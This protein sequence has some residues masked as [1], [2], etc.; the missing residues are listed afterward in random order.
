VSVNNGLGNI[1]EEMS[2]VGFEIQSWRLPGGW[3]HENQRTL[4]I[5]GLG[6]RF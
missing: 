2:V 6:P 4:R 1:Y 3:A 5:V